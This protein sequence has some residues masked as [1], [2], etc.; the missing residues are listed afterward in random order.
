MS[1]PSGVGGRT[2]V[3][4][5]SLPV[6]WFAFLAASFFYVVVVILLKRG[7]SSA[8]RP[9][10][11]FPF[12]KYLFYAVGGV[13]FSVALL[14]KRRLATSSAADAQTALRGAMTALVACLAVMEAVSILGIV[15]VALGG[16]PV[17]AIP[18]LAGGAIGIVLLRPDRSSLGDRAAARPP[19]GGSGREIDP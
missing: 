5:R 12:L 1:M 9:L 18:L 10:T 11:E 19:S 14:L 16:T 4:E 8:P 2:P 17:D 6:I 3:S 13:L 7:P 15:L